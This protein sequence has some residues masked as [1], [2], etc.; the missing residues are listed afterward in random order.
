MGDNLGI[1]DA[2]VFNDGTVTT[3]ASFAINNS[4][5]TLSGSFTMA[6][7]IGGGTNTSSTVAATVSA[8]NS[9]ITA[10][11]INLFPTPQAAGAYSGGLELDASFVGAN[12]FNLGQD[13]EIDFGLGGLN[14]ASPVTVGSSNSYANIASNTA[15]LAGDITA[16]F[17]FTPAPG[18]HDFDLITAVTVD[19]S[20]ANLNVINLPPLFRIVSFG[21]VNTGGSD[22]LRLTIEGG[23]DL[24]ITK[25][26]SATSSD[27]FDPVTYTITISNLGGGD[28]SNA[29]V[30]DVLPPTLDVNTA[31]WTCAASPGASCTATGNGNIVDIVD[32][33]QGGQVVYTLTAIVIGTEGEQ[34]INTAT[35]TPSPEAFDNITENNTDTDDDPIALFADSLEALDDE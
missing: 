11:S 15:T 30:S 18:R 19:V 13:G 28:V 25:R 10:D 17:N 5:V 4:T 23:N 9:S 8:A 27:M 29:D 26:N 33:P 24:E 1:A 12:S 3:D 7:V 2:D 31:V 35:V 6:E 21:V 20:S 14:P 22:V 16:D 34:I 32:I